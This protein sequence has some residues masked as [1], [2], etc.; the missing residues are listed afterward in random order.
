MKQQ[1]HITVNE[2]YPDGVNRFT[3][4]YSSSCPLKFRASYS[5]DDG[6]EINDLLY[7]EAGNEKEFSFLIEGYLENKKANRVDSLTFESF[8][9]EFDFTFDKLTAETIPVYSSSCHEI[10]G[11]RFTVGIKLSWGGGICEIIDCENPVP[12]LTNLVNQCD[13]GRLI[14]QSYYGTGANGEY[15]PGTFMESNWSYN[16]VQGGNKHNQPSRLIDL[17][18][19]ADSVWIRCQP[20]D[21]SNKDWLTPSYMENTYTVYDDRISVDNRF[22]DFSGWKHGI[23]SQEI[24]AFY[25]VSYLDSFV[26]YN[27]NAAWTGGALSYERNLNF[28]GDSRYHNDCE[29]G[30][31]S[32]KPETWCAW[33]NENDNYGIGLYVPGADMFLAGRFMYNASKDP[34]DGATNYVAPVNSFRLP[35]FKPFRYS[36]LLTCGSTEQ[37]RAVFEA[38]KNFAFNEEIISQ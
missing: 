24:P 11:M 3:L 5:L 26:H 2:K 33:V 36:Y 31:T 12:G 20:A 29:F 7:L 6:T 34:G 19:S 25:T 16:P 23:S 15:T 35:N 9:D 14:Q 1:K 27:G 22:I 8:G 17:K 10:K 32:N 21:W 38:N 37:I 28:W 13:T 4:L 30:N 18:I